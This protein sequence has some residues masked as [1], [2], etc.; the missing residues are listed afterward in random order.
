[1]LTEREKPDGRYGHENENVSPTP[2]LEKQ[3]CYG[4]VVSSKK[5]KKR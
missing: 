3:H 1:M 2:S 5:G 4:M